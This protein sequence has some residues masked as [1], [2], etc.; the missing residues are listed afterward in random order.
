VCG[1]LYVH[2]ILWLINHDVHQVKPVS[3]TSLSK[4]HA[5]IIQAVCATCS[6]SYV[7]LTTYKLWPW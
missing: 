4:A 3:I 7:P 1:N 2:V 5:L 6:Q